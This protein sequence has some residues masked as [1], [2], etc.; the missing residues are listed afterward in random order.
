MDI[1][2]GLSSLQ[3]RFNVNDSLFKNSISN[4]LIDV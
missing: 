3:S 4:P 2:K 1:T